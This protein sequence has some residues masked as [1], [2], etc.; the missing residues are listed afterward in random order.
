MQF[1]DHMHPTVLKCQSCPFMIIN[2][3]TFFLSILH[4]RVFIHYFF[5]F[6]QIHFIVTILVP[7]SLYTLHFLRFILQMQTH[8]SI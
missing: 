8:F 3:F 4:Q 6:M 7:P 2:F 1:E 5:L